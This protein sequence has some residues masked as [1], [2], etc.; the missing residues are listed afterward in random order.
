MSTLNKITLKFTTFL[1]VFLFAAESF[2][3]WDA[4]EQSWAKSHFLGGEVNSAIYPHD[5]KDNAND[6][7]SF[8]SCPLCPCCVSHVHMT[9]S[10]F[11]LSKEKSNL[12]ILPSEARQMADFSENY[13]FHP[14]RYS[15]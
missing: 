12:G 5:S 4:V 13:I 7:Q 11:T 14:P 1:L 6:S 10:F 8:D 15:S 3:L 2:A 9:I